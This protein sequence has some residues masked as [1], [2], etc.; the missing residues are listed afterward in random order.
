MVFSHT[1]VTRQCFLVFRLFQLLELWCSALRFC[2]HQSI[3]RTH[4]CCSLT[5]AIIFTCNYMRCNCATLS[6]AT[7][8]ARRGSD[9]RSKAI[10]PSEVA[11]KATADAITEA[12]MLR[13]EQSGLLLPATGQPILHARLQPVPI[14]KGV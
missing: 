12:V 1:L 14:Q 8:L 7:L 9:P 3:C 13:P 4:V 11:A 5:R 10:T 6:A 2:V